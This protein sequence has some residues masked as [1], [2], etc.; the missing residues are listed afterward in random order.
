MRKLKSAPIPKG[1]LAKLKPVTMKFSLK[2]NP[3]FKK[4]LAVCKR[5][6]TKL[7]KLSVFEIVAK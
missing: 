4:Q 3:A 5:E 7:S 2:E 6:L 1:S